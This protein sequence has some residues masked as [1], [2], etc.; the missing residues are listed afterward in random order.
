MCMLCLSRQAVNS[1]FAL[2]MHN[3]LSQSQLAVFLDAYNLERGLN[4]Q[5][6]RSESVTIYSDKPTPSGILMAFF[7][8][9]LTLATRSCVCVDLHDWLIMLGYLH[10]TYD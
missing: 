8:Q 6:C 7:Q 10:D 9:I 1:Q 4:Y 2:A 5:V 3:C